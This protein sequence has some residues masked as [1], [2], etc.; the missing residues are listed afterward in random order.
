MVDAL[1]KPKSEKLLPQINTD[2]YNKLKIYLER[3]KDLNEEVFCNNMFYEKCMKKLQHKQNY[4]QTCKQ[5]RELLFP[6][7]ANDRFGCDRNHIAKSWK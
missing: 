7:Q 2:E 5:A 3:I 1:G 6:A 4:H